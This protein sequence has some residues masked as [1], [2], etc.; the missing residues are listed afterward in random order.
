M[1]WTELKKVFRHSAHILIN[2]ELPRHRFFFE[3]SS[4]LKNVR[5]VAAGLFH[6]DGHGDIE[7]DTTK[8]TANFRN[9]ANVT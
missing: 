1:Q 3:K 9:S 4:N 6:A 2:L 8:L 5:P 7:T